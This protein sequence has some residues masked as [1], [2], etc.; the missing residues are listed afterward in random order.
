MNPDGTASVFVIADDPAVG[1][2]YAREL[3]AGG[4]HVLRASSFADVLGSHMPDMV[5][6][7]GL[8]VLAYPSQ[9]VRVLRVSTGMSPHALVREVHRRVA[10][11][12]T[13]Q[14][15]IARAA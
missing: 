2:P 15:T 6:L 8:A 3:E 10:L 1:E 9:A 4:Y 14:A 12:A 13:L 11:G 7:A 5:V